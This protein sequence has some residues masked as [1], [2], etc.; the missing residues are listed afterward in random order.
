MSLETSDFLQ[1]DDINKVF[2]VVEAVSAGLITDEQIENYLGLNS[3]SRQGRY[4]RL[5]AEKIGLIINSENNASLTTTGQFFINS[6]LNERAILAQNLIASLPVFSQVISHFR[7]N[8]PININQLNSYFLSIYP[9]EASTAARRFSTF[10][11]YIRYL[12]LPIH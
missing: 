6:S 8:I 11:N 7:G 12:G 9:G 3:K 1:A 2:R 5:A 10:M 4:Y